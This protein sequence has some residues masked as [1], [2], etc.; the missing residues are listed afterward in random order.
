MAPRQSERSGEAH[1]ADDPLVWEPTHAFLRYSIGFITIGGTA[2]A[3]AIRVLAPDQVARALMVSAFVGVGLIAALLLA[4]GRIRASFLVQAT[5][6]WTYISVAGYLFGGV[7]AVSV[8]I[9]PLIILMLG[10]LVHPRAALLLAGLSSAVTLVYAVSEVAGLLPPAPATSP[11]LRW[12]VDS[13]VFFLSALL[14]T[15]L[16]HSYRSRLEEVQRL[17]TYVADRNAEV[18]AREAQLEGILAST[19]EGILAVG[20][21]GRVIRTNRRFAE[22]WRIPDDVIGSR[23]D[24]RLLAHV[25]GQLADPDGFIA[26][27]R[28]LYESDA[29]ST[30]VVAFKDGRLF[31][32][33]TAP[34]LTD[35][36]VTGRIWSFRDITDRTRLEH[37]HLQAQ[38][39]ASLG[40]LAG[41]I[42]HDFNN[43]LAAIRANVDEAAVGVP[44]DRP[45]AAH[46]RDI[47]RSTERAADLVRRIMTFARP[48]ES[49]VEPVR[50]QHVTSEVLDLLRSTLPTSIA[51]RT[52][53]AP[54][55]KDV[56]ADSSQVHEVIVNLTTNA[57][58]AIGL[59]AGA[60]TYTLDPVVVDDGAASA[61]PGLSPGGY[62]RLSVTDDGCG[63]DRATVERIFDAFYTTKPVG[64]GTGLGLSM[65]HG[66][67]TA[68]GGAVTV[69]STPGVGSTFSLYF[70]VSAVPANDVAPTRPPTPEPRAGGVR[71]LFVDDEP[72]L[73]SVGQRMLTRFGHTVS[74]FPDPVAALEAFSAAPDDFDVV[75]TDLAMPRLSGTDL[76]RAVLALRPNLPVV[77]VTGRI[78]DGD[79][80]HVREAGVR[81]LLL[82]PFGA[83]QLSAAID[84]ALHAAA[85][86][87]PPV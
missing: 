15:Q 61:V 42:A 5:G 27:V 36:V 63:M 57:A 6:I 24:R 14:V 51:L 11:V 86:R 59:R 46:L 10:W 76:T 72:L 3:I 39:L 83:D 71:V 85:A 26:L 35:S 87:V 23:D 7:D 64:Q 55:V 8:Y 40:T 73:V 48:G 20:Q 16:R 49:R 29:S 75:V 56:L 43:I 13:C 44:A 66:I 58:H 34:M 62:T 45:I 32:R 50:L 12:L 69:D 81:E 84:R 30:D 79:R 2:V 77:L 82:K 54:D 80:V 67:M 78:G 1:G 52:R 70:P 25:A 4:A 28:A 53:V 38:K 21:C 18:L 68:H 41:G 19:S 60:I 65:V 37:A 22:L 47:R 31:E 33:Y 74:G 17:N 9:Y